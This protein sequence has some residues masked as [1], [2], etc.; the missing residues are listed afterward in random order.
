MDKKPQIQ[1]PKCEGTGELWS[2]D[3][4]AESPSLTCDRCNGTG[5]IP[6][7]EPSPKDK[8]GCTCELANGQQPDS[9]VMDEYRDFDCVE[10]GLL[11]KQGKDKTSCKYWKP[12]PEPMPLIELEE[13]VC[14]VLADPRGWCKE[15]ATRRIMQSIKEWL[16]SHDQQVRKDFAEECIKTMPT[17]DF[18][19]EEHIR[20]GLLQYE[21]CIAH[22]RAMVEEK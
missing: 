19:K 3:E 1:C 5:L 16:P 11:R 8:S 20:A 13:D 18:T 21:T 22:L 7:V 17:V 15:E 10:A 6:Y 14:L 4:K 12:Q 2:N 9:C